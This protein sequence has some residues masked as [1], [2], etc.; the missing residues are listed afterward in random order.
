MTARMDTEPIRPARACPVCAGT[1]ATLLQ[2]MVFLLPDDHPL[3][4]RYGIVRCSACGFV[5]ADTA[6]TQA[7]YD[8][9]YAELSKYSDTATGTGAGHQDWDRARLK[10]TAAFVAE[11]LGDRASRV[12][13]I[14]CANGGLLAEFLDLGFQRLVGVDP[15]AACAASATAIPGVSGYI[16]SI[17]DLPDE[18]HDVDCVVL[19]HVLEHVRD[20]PE[21]L[22]ILRRVL[23]PG[24]IAYVEVPD[25]TRYAQFLIAPFQDFNVEHINHF[26]ALSLA[27]ALRRAGFA[28]ERTR[29]KAISASATATY[30][31]VGVIARAVDDGSHALERDAPLGDAIIE[32]I[33]RS[34]EALG[35]VQAHLDRALADV[36]EIV[37]WGTGQTTL[38]VLSNVRLSPRVVALTD[39]NTRYHG[40]RLGGIPIV[41]PEQLGEFDVPIVV[42]SLI[43]HLAIEHRIRQLG[44]PNRT[45]RLSPT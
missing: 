22:R 25:A 20:V 23:R 7:D 35:V 4:D 18:V 28:V 16:G 5:Y 34:R 26:S 21:A 30:P 8:R 44:L 2:R 17:F 36:S 39:S 31:A 15:S 37:I 10:D 12:V 13:D 11:S 38:T 33:D 32:Y 19:S 45:I 40:R 14:G 42:G 27:N 3:A 1:I 43:S 9:Y 6:S 24:G 29:G 41:P